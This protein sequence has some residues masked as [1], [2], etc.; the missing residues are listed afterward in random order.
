MKINVIIPGFL[1]VVSLISCSPYSANAPIGNR[2]ERLC[3]RVREWVS[4][5]WMPLDQAE[6]Y[7]GDCA[8]FEEPSNNE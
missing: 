7:Y 2:S 8:P 5:G 1:A 4:E 3:E 6:T